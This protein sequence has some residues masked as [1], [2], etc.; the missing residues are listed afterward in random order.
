MLCDADGGGCC[1]GT[2]RGCK[3][4]A[5][6][7]EDIDVGVVRPDTSPLSPQPWMSFLTYFVIMMM[8]RAHLSAGTARHSLGQQC[9]VRMNA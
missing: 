2:L 4:A 1:A 3:S 5:E 7:E 8:M 9:S 6:Y